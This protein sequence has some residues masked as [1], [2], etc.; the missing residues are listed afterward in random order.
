MQYVRNTQRLFCPPTQAAKL[1]DNG[2][3][4]ARTYWWKNVK[5]IVLTVV[6][7]V[8]IVLLIILLAIGV[9]PVSAPVPTIISPTSKP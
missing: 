4:V 6:V 7:S 1:A 3:R 9:I 5:V 8:I 2:N